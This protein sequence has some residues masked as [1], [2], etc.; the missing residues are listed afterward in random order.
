MSISLRTNVSSL[1][2]QRTLSKTRNALAVNMSKLSSGLRVRNAA[3]DAAGLAISEKMKAQIRSLH[4]AQRNANY[5]ISLIQTA[6]GALNEMHGVMDRMRELAVQSANGTYTNEDRLFINDEFSALTS[7]LDRIVDVT[8]F[9]GHKLLDG[10]ESSNSFQVGIN[11]NAEDR[12]SISLVDM[13]V[14]ALGGAT[15]VNDLSVS[16]AT[17]ALAAINNIDEAIKD[18]STQRSKFGAVQNRL[19]VASSNLASYR[20]NLSAANSQIRDVDVAEESANMTRNNILMQA[21]TSVLSQA[22]MSPQIALS[23]IG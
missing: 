14:T 13:S 18:I 2:A 8:E 7:E 17:N 19:Q 4:Q 21:G 11:N 9:N 10:S 12:I 6:D 20:E 22:N 16:T 23:L 3:D 1:N 5:G 15:T